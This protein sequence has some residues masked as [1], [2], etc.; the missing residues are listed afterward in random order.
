MDKDGGKVALISLSIACFLLLYSTVAFY[1][2][3]EGEKGKKNALQ[4][5]LDEITVLKQG[6]DV[7]LKDAD[8]LTVELKT[9]LKTQEET[10]ADIT[11]KLDEEKQTNAAGSLKLGERENEMRGLK[12]DLENSK[13][14]AA[15][16]AR[17]IAKA[18]DDYLKI[19]LQ[20]DN[21]S[22][23]KEDAAV[24][25]KEILEKEGVSLGT[26]VVNH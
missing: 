6:T 10:I 11:K 17:K 7:K 24:K 5:K 26:V 12:V 3:E 13:A 18:N 21:M 9:R 1:V 4:K 20:M 22:K 2:M 16:L 14:Q 19:K 8:A 15:D 25:S 23:A